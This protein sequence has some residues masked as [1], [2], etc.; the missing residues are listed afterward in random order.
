MNR[1]LR[2]GFF[3][4]IIS[5]AIWLF[6]CQSVADPDAASPQADRKVILCFGNS[7]TAG[8]GLDPSQAFPALI[9]K[10]IDALGWPFTVVNAGLSGE[11]TAGGLRRIDWLLRRPID[12][13]V[14]ELGANDGFRGIDVAVTRN[15]LQAIINKT[16]E[17]YPQVRIV[18][19]GMQIP[20][21]LGRSYATQFRSIFPELA[22]KNDALLIPFFLE[23]VGGRP[24]LNLPDGIH[25][26]AEGYR[27]VANNVWEVLEPLLKSMH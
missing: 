27:I 18:I 19:A 10:K 14:L 13:L 7:L 11:T 9:Q 26:T 6:A 17:K 16:K 21:N 1:P 3:A 5:L 23:G 2:I 20:P 12:V 8:Y 15:N 22:E 24:E 25:P 4:C